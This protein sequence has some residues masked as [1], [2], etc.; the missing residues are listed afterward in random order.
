VVRIKL[1]RET[2]A[3]F[4]GN[5]IDRDCE[6]VTFE[7]YF[8]ILK[9]TVVTQSRIGDLGIASGQVIYRFHWANRCYNLSKV[10]S[11]AGGL[12]ANWFQL[13]DSVSLSA[14]EVVWR[15]LNLILLV[16]PD[17]ALQEVKGEDRP[18]LRET[19]LQIFI[20]A[21]KQSLLR[22]YGEIIMETDRLLAKYQAEQAV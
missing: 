10:I 15:D 20:A 9:H 8:A 19:W 7:G 6:L 4:S 2:Q 13:A 21:T 12:T 17:G 22:K 18:P 3:F 14:T 11:D 16:R 1:Y 5:R